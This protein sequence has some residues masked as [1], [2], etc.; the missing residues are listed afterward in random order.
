MDKVLLL[1][2]PAGITSFDAVR[3]CRKIFHEKKIGHTGTLDPEASGLLIVLTGKYTKLN[4]YCMKDDKA[5]TAHFSFGIQTDTQD[6]WGKRTAEKEP[7]PHTQQQLDEAALKMTGTLM[8]M[9]PMYSAR[10]VNGKKLYEYARKGI[11]IER[12]AREITVS[13]LSVKQTGDNDFEMKAVVSGGTYIRT[14]ITDYASLL[15][16]YACMTSLVR[17]A[18]G[19][20]SLADAYELDDLT[21]DTP[22]FDPAIVIDKIWE[23]VE[24]EQEEA[25]RNGRKLKLEG[26]SGHVLL[27]HNG[28]LLAVYEKREDGLYHSVRGLF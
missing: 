22:S 8:Q 1:N 24:C 11:E 19:T 9:P 15:G 17:T 5:Y 2:K 20:A 12:E 10:K 21:E 25:V 18:I 27:R 6:I 13:S 4:P 28:N 16:E 26:C 14:L 7:V 23:P 3:R